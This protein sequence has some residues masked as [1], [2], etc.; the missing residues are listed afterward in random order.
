LFQ[1]IALNFK[2]VKSCP[3]EM[4]QELEKF[5]RD[6]INEVQGKRSESAT[7]KDA[8]AKA[9]ELFIAATK[10]EVIGS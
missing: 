9:L 5:R 7:E 1:T 2:D 8:S 6:W 4:E 3:K 10:Q